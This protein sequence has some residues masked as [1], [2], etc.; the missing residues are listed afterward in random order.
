MAVAAERAGHRRATRQVWQTRRCWALP[1]ALAPCCCLLL[2]ACLV[3]CVS[4]HEPEASGQR[5]LLQ[6]AAPRLPAPLPQP[7]PSPPPPPPPPPPNPHAPPRPPRPPPMPPFEAFDES[8]SRSSTW[9]IAVAVTLPLFILLAC[10]LSL[11]A[12]RH[13]AARRQAARAEAASASASAALKRREADTAA[14]HAAHSAL[15][16]SEPA[17]FKDPELGTYVG[18]DAGP[19]Q[20]EAPKKGQR[21]KWYA[22]ATCSVIAA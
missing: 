16:G 10:C 11:H 21:G 4:A 8:Q 2:L 22:L 5:G 15:P 17:W 12:H 18:V 1:G 14:A 20:P 19:W 6:G 13:D 7:P 9:L 3:T